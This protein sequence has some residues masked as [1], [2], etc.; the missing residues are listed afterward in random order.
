[1]ASSVAD[2]RQPEGADRAAERQ[3]TERQAGDPAHGGAHRHLPDQRPEHPL[4]QPAFDR[5]SSEQ[6][7]AQVDEGER[8]RVVQPRLGGE[9][10]AHGVLLGVEL[11]P[12]LGRRRGDVHLR[13]QHRVCRGQHRPEEHRRGDGQPHGPPAEQ[14]HPDDAQGHGDGQQPPRRPPR[15]PVQRA[16]DG[17]ADAH[18]RHDD[19]RLGQM[20]RG[21]G[22]KER[23]DRVLAGDH[24]TREDPEAQHHHRHRQRPPVHDTRQHGGQQQ[25]HAEHQVHH[26]GVHRATLEAADAARAAPTGTAGRGARAQREKRDSAG[27]VTCDGGVRSLTAA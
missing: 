6:E 23:G 20:R 13:G 19:A 15:A 21:R 12:A 16:V 22:V 18:Q 25:P 3:P 24:R 1:M 27:S 10:E 5:S 2:L 8:Q 4:G 14:G 17:Q 9:R 26:V 7:Q 11:L